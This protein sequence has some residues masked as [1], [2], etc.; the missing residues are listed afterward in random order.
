VPPH[1]P[2]RAVASDYGFFNS[3][4]SLAMFAATRRASSRAGWN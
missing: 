3:S 1:W 4:G 2:A